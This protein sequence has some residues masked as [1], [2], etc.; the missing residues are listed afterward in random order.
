MW[1]AANGSSLRAVGVGTAL[2]G[3]G[4]DVLVC[5]D[6]V[7]SMAAATSPAQCEAAENWFESTALGRLEPGASV[8]VNAHRWSLDDLSARL[9]GQAWPWA[10]VPAVNAQGQSNWP[11]RWSTDELRAKER[12]VGSIVWAALY[13]GTPRPR[14]GAV[15]VGGPHFYDPH[16]VMAHVQAGSARIAIGVDPA[17][18]ARTSADYSAIVVAAFITEYQRIEPPKVPARPMTQ[19]ELVQFAQGNNPRRDHIECT[20]MNI[21]DVWRGQVEIPD[22]VQRIA[23]VQRHWRA[24]VGVESVGGFRGVAQYLARAGAG[25]V[26]EVKRTVDKLTASIPASAAWARAEIRV[27]PDAASRW[28]QF[29]DEVMRFTGTGADRNDDQVDAMTIAHSLVALAQH[30]DRK[31][32]AAARIRNAFPFG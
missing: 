4:A 28:P 25:A 9:I 10:N 30:A 8:I 14:G 15:F 20:T 12:E 16:V 7:P 31:R 19:A 27:P 18:N 21:V 1:T 6:L 24:P 2:V 3:I 11:S 32:S 26:H 17:T 5:D 22:L 29:L 23:E 13:C